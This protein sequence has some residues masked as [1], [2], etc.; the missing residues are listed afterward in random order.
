MSLSRAER[1][2]HFVSP[3]AAET[4]NVLGPTI[5]FL[6]PPREGDP[7]L[8]RGAIPPGGVVPLHSHPAPETFIALEG[9]VEALVLEADGG[10]RW[11][12]VHA[13]DIYHVPGDAPHA[14]RNPSDAP[15]VSDLVTTATMGFFFREVGTPPG[16]ATQPPDDAALRRFLETAERYGYWNA[17]PEE[18]ARV[19]ITPP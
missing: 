12:P 19:G 6:T 16:E 17:T 2:A 13:G 14:W 4:L 10:H 9:E 8:I 5:R 1:I 18:N 15:A 11:V 3:D 7:C